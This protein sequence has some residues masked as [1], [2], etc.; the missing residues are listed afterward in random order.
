MGILLWIVTVLDLHWETGGLGQMITLTTMA[1]TLVILFDSRQLKR[2][3]S[4][5]QS[6]A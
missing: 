2:R 4:S 3:Q 6:A 5:N 1:G